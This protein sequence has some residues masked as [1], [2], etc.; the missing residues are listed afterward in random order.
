MKVLLSMGKTSLNNID[1][2]NAALKQRIIGLCINDGEFSLADLSKEIGTSIP[3]TTKL[4]EE[5][6]EEG[7]LEDRGKQGTNGGRRPNIFGLN[8]AAGY[9]VG[10][11]IRHKNIC[12]AV[13]DFNGTELLYK[14]NVPYA[15]QNS[16]DSFIGLCN[17][18]KESLTENNID[19]NKV[20]AYGF[21]L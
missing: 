20:L 10:V 5:L 15:V 1:G 3:T 6:L 2:K 16:E 12:F 13:T 8:S 17:L 21:T 18:I 9:F 4:V 7:L 11:D 14:E 19:S